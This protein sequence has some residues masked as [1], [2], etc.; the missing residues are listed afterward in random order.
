MH[1][2]KG[3]RPLAE[4]PHLAP[5]V[6]LLVQKARC[7]E[8]LESNCPLVRLVL[9]FLLCQVLLGGPGSRFLGGVTLLA[10]LAF[11]NA[12]AAAVTIVITVVIVVRRTSSLA[13]CI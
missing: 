5:R 13:E 7:V 8:A 6:A 11:A 4:M 2:G 12:A 10:T 3:K 1:Q 9:G